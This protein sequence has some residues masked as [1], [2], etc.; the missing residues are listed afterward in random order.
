MQSTIPFPVLKKKKKK[1]KNIWNFSK[2]S[3]AHAFFLQQIA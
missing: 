1:K 2:F 3:P